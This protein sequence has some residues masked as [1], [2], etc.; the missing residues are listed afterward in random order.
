MIEEVDSKFTHLLF[1]IIGGNLDRVD[2]EISQHPLPQAAFVFPS[3]P[4]D[5]LANSRHHVHEK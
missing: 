4:L 1:G 3:P 2:V 5:K